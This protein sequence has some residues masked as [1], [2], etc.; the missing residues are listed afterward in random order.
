MAVRRDGGVPFGVVSAAG[1]AVS[2]GPEVR[3]SPE[4]WQVIRPPREVSALAEWRGSS[5]PEEPDGLYAIDPAGGEPTP[6]TVASLEGRAPSLHQLVAGGSSGR[7]WVGHDA[8]VTVYAP[9]PPMN[10]GA[11]GDETGPTLAGAQDA[12]PPSPTLW[13]M[14][15]RIPWSV[16]SPKLHGPHLGR[17]TR[18][19]VIE[20]GRIAVWIPSGV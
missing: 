8:G 6:G 5:G 10:G 12:F 20:D 18:R 3:E 15:Y 2:R 7:L 19:A 13:Q 11:S 17:P 4:G 14:A 9:E 16:A 1:Y